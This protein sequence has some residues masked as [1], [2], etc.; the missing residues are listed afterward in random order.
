MSRKSIYLNP[1]MI[2]AM[3]ALFISII[4]AGVS[5]YSASTDCQYAKAS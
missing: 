5:I 1:E 3:S 4:T 2:V